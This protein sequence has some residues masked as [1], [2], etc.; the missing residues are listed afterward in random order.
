MILLVPFVNISVECTVAGGRHPVGGAEVEAGAGVVEGKP[1]ASQGDISSPLPERN[2]L[3]IRYSGLAL[4]ASPGL[5]QDSAP[6]V[7]Q[8]GRLA[9]LQG[10]FILNDTNMKTTHHS[11]IR[12]CNFTGGLAA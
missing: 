7:A 5:D 12:V 2:Q 1:G 4:L 10:S 11:L 8:R 9:H 6:G 3:L